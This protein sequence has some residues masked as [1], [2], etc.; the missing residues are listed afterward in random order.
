MF[1]S[2]GVMF[3]LTRLR[4]RAQKF[5]FFPTDSP[6]VKAL[7]E[8]PVFFPKTFVVCPVNSLRRL[9]NNFYKLLIQSWRNSPDLH[10]EII[11]S[12]TELAVSN[13]YKI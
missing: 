13:L 12:R 10:A 11:N 7:G 1:L 5:L 3:H 4:L 2:E 9:G 6:R 8:S